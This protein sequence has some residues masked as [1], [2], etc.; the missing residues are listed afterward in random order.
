[1]PPLPYLFPT[2]RQGTG[3]GPRRSV[4]S[5]KQIKDPEVMGLI[6]GQKPDSKEEWWTALWL[7][8]HGFEFMYQ[9]LVFGDRP[10]YFYKIDFL[11]HTVP[12]KT[13]LEI[14]GNYWHTGE[15]GMDDRRRQVEIEEALGGYCKTPMS[16]LWRGDLE[17]RETLEAALGRIFN[18]N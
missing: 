4:P 12:M 5:F 14:Y 8:K 15:L 11:V 13:I 9:F 18:A 7:W 16:I 10:K 1:M 3:K 6:Y 17:S 2:G